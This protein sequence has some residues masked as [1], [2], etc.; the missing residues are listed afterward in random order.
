V[1]E[2][3]LFFLKSSEFIQKK[4]L[5]TSS[6]G[7]AS[8]VEARLTFGTLRSTAKIVIV[9]FAKPHQLVQFSENRAISSAQKIIMDIST[10]D[11]I[12]LSQRYSSSNK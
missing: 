6:N 12:L 10:P 7:K 8:N 9:D 1:R 3:A 11:L 4:G 5:R 2:G